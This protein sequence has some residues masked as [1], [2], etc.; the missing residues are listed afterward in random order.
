MIRLDALD[1]DP[2]L[3]ITPP[4]ASRFT[5]TRL[6]LAQVHALLAGIDAVPDP[7][8]S[9]AYRLALSLG[10]RRGELAGLR[11]D[12]I[13]LD[14]GT[15]RVART[16]VV[17]GRR[18]IDQDD[19][20]SAT[21]ARTVHL[22]PDLTARLRA[23]R[24]AQSQQRLALGTGWADTAHGGLVLT[25]ATGRGVSPEKL[26]K[27]L[28]SVL[29]GAGLPTTI[30]LHDLRHASAALG[31]AA[32]ETMVEVQ[33]RLGHAQQSLTADLYSFAFSEAAKESAKRRADLLNGTLP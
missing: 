25:D 10:L 9:L 17:A 15:L 18:I 28:R 21:S 26:T 14:D 20:K 22:D 11:W 2:T 1:H 7:A 6:S 16:R 30:R 24:T 33:R 13:S 29:K 32:G 19:A 3:G 31:A 27:G 12:A 8:L 4:K 23:Y 5:H